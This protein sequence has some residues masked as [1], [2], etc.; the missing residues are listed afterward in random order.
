MVG[1]QQ[2]P[3][4][5]GPGG[6][7]LVV[8]GQPFRVAEV[9]DEAAHPAD[10][11]GDHLVQRRVARGRTA[12]LPGRGRGRG[13][14]QPQLEPLR[15]GPDACRDV[16]AVGS[17]PIFGPH[18]GGLG[19]PVTGEGA[20]DPVPQ[21]ADGGHP[22]GGVEGSRRRR[23]EQRPGGGGQGPEAAGTDLH[24]EAV[25]H[26][27]L[28]L[29]GLVEHHHL[30]GR[31]HS[32]PAGQVG[33]VEMGVDHDDIGLG[34]PGPGGL[35]E[36]LP[37][38]GAPEGPGALPCG[39]RDHGPGPEM[40]FELEFG[41]V[42]GGGVVGPPHETT[43][44]LAETAHLGRVVRRGGVAARDGG[45]GVVG[46]GGVG[47]SGLEGHLLAPSAD[48]G[49][50]LPAEVVAPSFQHGE[51]EAPVDGGGHQ[52]QVVVGQLV[53]EG[54]GGRRHHHSF[55]GEGRRDQVG[56]GL[57]GARAGLDHQVTPVGDGPFHRL[58]H[59]L[60]PR[61][62]LAAVG[63]ARRHRG[64][65]AGHVVGHVPTLSASPDRLRRP[66]RGL[67]HPADALTTVSATRRPA[68][69]PRPDPRPR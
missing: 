27:L 57:A 34:G 44:L 20:Q 11:Q 5:P 45:E 36:A 48:L 26:H 3:V 40:G 9:I 43:D 6:R 37:A 18:Q 52:W 47:R 30:M 17:G 21:I 61:S 8:P 69:P 24:T 62:G 23:V 29:V 66:G 54:L 63:E 10:G 2:R 25:G 15:F 41:P 33:P 19:D 50:P 65:R 12:A 35:G 64:Q 49:D 28:H 56:Q 51:G 67:G 38:G 16:G 58:G 7:C 55:T 22:L 14:V 59:R 60:L 39:G 32:A 1:G 4:P 68:P 46:V 13:P 31:E 42:P 53:L